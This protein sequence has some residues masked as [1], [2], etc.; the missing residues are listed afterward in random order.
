VAVP[1]VGRTNALSDI[2]HDEVVSAYDDPPLPRAVSL[3]VKVA[4]PLAMLGIIF[5][6]LTAIAGWRIGA[7]VMLGAVCL[8]FTWH[9]VAG[10]AGYCSVM[11]RPWPKVAP[12][13]DDEW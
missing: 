5:G 2:C 8:D 4:A 11:R 13:E 1:A 6:F 12:L 10:I 9:L 7:F 3:L